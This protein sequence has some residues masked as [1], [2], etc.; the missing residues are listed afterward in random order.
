MK[1]CNR[2]KSTHINPHSPS[3]HFFC[4]QYKFLGPDFLF[5]AN[6]AAQIIKKCFMIFHKWWETKCVSV[7]NYLFLPWNHKFFRFLIYR[8]AFIG[9]YQPMQAKDI[10]PCPTPLHTKNN[11]LFILRGRSNWYCM[12]HFLNSCILVYKLLYIS[13]SY[14]W[15]QKLS[16]RYKMISEKFWYQVIESYI[17]QLCIKYLENFLSV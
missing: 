11:M 10:S 3:P 9:D 14:I 1:G 5:D 2:L 4:K 17:S 8:G 16:R 12:K 13:I 15:I 6:I 7:Y